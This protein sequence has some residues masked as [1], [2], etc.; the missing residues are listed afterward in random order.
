MG[1]TERGAQV[2]TILRTW[3]IPMVRSIPHR[4]TSN[5]RENDLVQ[6]KRD[7]QSLRKLDDRDVHGRPLIARRSLG[8]RTLTDVHQAVSE[9]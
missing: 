8:F 5:L 3:L 4:I 1:M 6:R 9:S 2:A 7:T